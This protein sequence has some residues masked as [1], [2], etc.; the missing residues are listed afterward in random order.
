MSKQSNYKKEI[1]KN[2]YI[3]KEAIK[4]TKKQKQKY[5][6]DKKSTKNKR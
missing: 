4:F 2:K 6:A 1:I 3:N 5:H